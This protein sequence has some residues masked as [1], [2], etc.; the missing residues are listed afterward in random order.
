MGF[1]SRPRAVHTS[2]CVRGA[3]K[4]P[5]CPAGGPSAREPLRLHGPPAPQEAA[6]ALLDSTQLVALLL[7][8]PRIL[9]FEQN[10][11]TGSKCWKEQLPQPEPGNVSGDVGPRSSSGPPAPGLSCLGQ[12]QSLVI[13]KEKER[14]LHLSVCLHNLEIQNLESNKLRTKD[15]GLGAHS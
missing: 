8:T 1:I 11:D 6:A 2:L 10:S 5:L 3:R 14:C 9:K 15:L 12:K 7:V 13:W 4:V